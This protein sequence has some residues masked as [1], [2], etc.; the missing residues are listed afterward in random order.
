LRAAGIDVASRDEDLVRRGDLVTM[1][2]IEGHPRTGGSTWQSLERGLGSVETDYLNGEIVLL[3]RRL[4][5]PTPVN[6]VLQTTMWE[7]A[8]EKRPPGSYAEDDLRERLEDRA[9][10]APR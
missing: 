4:G 1:G 2:Q 7:A 8:R 5:I 6:E 3:G 9:T 10:P